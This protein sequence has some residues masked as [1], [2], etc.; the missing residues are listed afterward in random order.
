[1]GFFPSL[2]FHKSDT[3]NWH[4][5]L[6]DVMLRLQSISDTCTLLTGRCHFK[7]QTHLLGCYKGKLEVL[8]SEDHQEQ[9]K[10]RLVNGRG[11]MD[12]KKRTVY[13]C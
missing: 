2:L 8:I 3:F 11:A 12:E 9:G 1:M 7:L 4:S 6:K 10:D 5:H 13:S